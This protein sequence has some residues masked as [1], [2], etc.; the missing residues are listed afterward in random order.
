MKVADALFRL[1]LIICAWIFI[2]LIASIAAQMMDMS[3]LVLKTQGWKFFTTA[4]WNPVKKEFGVLAFAYGTILTSVLALL[5]STPLSIGVAVSLTELLPKRSAQF[6]GFAVEMLAAIP[7]V[8]YGLWGLNVLVPVMRESVQPWLYE[9]LGFLPIFNSIPY[10]VGVLT[11]AIV[12]SIMVLPTMASVLRDVFRSIPIQQRE[13][14]LGIGAT[15]TEMIRVAV[16]RSSMPSVIG[17]MI[18]G[19]GRALGETMAVTMVIGN[20][21]GWVKSILEPGQTMASLIANEYVE[22]SQDIHL[23]ALSGVGLTLLIVS[24]VIHLWFRSFLKPRVR[25]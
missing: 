6:L 5:I 19:L 13:A 3:W 17:A 18:L 15:R 7:S 11:A 14:A 10:G 20:S 25:V 22:A 9:N 1:V 24:S 12:L 2:V 21:N 4:V 8:V 23:S 16:L